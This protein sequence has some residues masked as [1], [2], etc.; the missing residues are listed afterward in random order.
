M[1]LTIDLV[2]MCPYLHLH[3]LL[4]IFCPQFADQLKVSEP[5]VELIGEDCDHDSE[6]FRHDVPPENSDCD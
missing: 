2:S 5:S 6:Y 1:L 3:L 4:H